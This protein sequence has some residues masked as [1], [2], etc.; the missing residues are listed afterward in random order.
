MADTSF[1]DLLGVARD[2]DDAAIKAAFRKAAMKHHPD[3]NPNDPS[4]E[5]RFKEVNEAYSVLSNPETR[6]RYDRFGRAGV[7][8]GSG[9]G[10]NSAD[11]SD[12]L[13][14]VFGDMFSEFFGGTRSRAGQRGPQRGQDLRYDIEVSLE[15]AYSGKDLQISAPI[16]EACDRCEGSGAEPGTKPETCPTCDGTGHVRVQQ[17]FFTMQRTCVRCGGRGVIIPK[18]CKSCNGRGAIKR[19]R[20]L[21]VR[22]PPGVEDGMRIRLQG[23][24]ER[25]PQ[26]GPPGDLYLFV[27]VL[28]HE[29]YERDGAELYCRAPVTMTA[30]ALGGEIM[31]PTLDGVTTKLDI[32]EGSQTGRR[33]RLKGKGMPKVRGGVPGD[34]TVELFVETPRNLTGKQ[35][36]LLK[37]FAAISDDKHSPESAGFF[38]KLKRLFDS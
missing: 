17:G 15:E 37:E 2:A 11:M 1:Y 14:E 4:A 27:S 18:P 33:L 24:G 21:G 20:T 36:S 5:A 31:I 19:D 28:A 13:N 22:V 3:R 9:G 12:V 29:I 16:D 38:D 32:P 26:G 30:A 6:A 25:G 34:L 7:N 23:E 10:P 8:G 35:K